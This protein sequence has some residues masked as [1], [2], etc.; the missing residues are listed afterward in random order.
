MI[1]FSATMW[2]S[3]LF[4][5][6]ASFSPPLLLQFFVVGV[7]LSGTRRRKGDEW[8]L[9]RMRCSLHDSE[10]DREMLSGDDS[11]DISSFRD[12]ND[13]G[14]I[15]VNEQSGSERAGES[16]RQYR[17]PWTKRIVKYT[18]SSSRRTGCHL[19]PSRSHTI[20][21]FNFVSNLIVTLR[22]N[23]VASNMGHKCAPQ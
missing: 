17:W 15:L 1:L 20:N 18:A 10:I 5:L 7:Q 2:C 14:N 9:L 8:V 4:Q 23:I 21:L 6:W 11:S 12:V 22:E 13:C 19:P 16:I 3:A